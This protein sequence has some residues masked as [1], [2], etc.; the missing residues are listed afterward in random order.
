MKRIEVANLSF[1]HEFQGVLILDDVNFSVG[2]NEILAIL[3]PNGAG[4][5]TLIHCI[6]GLCRTHAGVVRLFGNDISDLSRG[7]IAKYVAYVPQASHA[8]FAFTVEQMVLMGRTAHITAM[9]SPSRRDREFAEQSIVDVGIGHLRRKR[10][11]QLS[12]G[13]RQLVLIARALAQ[14]ARIIVMDEPTA[15]LD[16]SNQGRVLSLMREMAAN[17]KSVIMTTHLPDQAFNLQCRVALLKAGRLLAAGP[18]ETICTPDA[19][20][21]LYDARLLQL[22]SN[23][24]GGLAAYVPDL[25]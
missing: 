19:M 11:T 17:G 3:G 5:S 23:A 14:D 20:S 1:R 25:S 18:V 8:A 12:G 7:E 10:F 16:L 13:E 2:D 15:N 24:N 6:L 22:C 9:G 21:E 4:K